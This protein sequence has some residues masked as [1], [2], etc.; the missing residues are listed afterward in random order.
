MKTLSQILKETI[1][2]S[3]EDIATISKALTSAEKELSVYQSSMPLSKDYD[4]KAQ[5]VANVRGLINVS[6]NLIRR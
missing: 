6:L 2:I 5:R 3:Q 1:V 4:N